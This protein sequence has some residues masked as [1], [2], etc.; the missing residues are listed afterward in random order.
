MVVWALLDQQVRIPR[1]HRGRRFPGRRI[2]QPGVTILRF[3]GDTLSYGEAN[4]QVNR[5]ANVLTAQGVRTGDVVGILME[6]KPEALLL[7]LGL[8]PNDLEG[9]V[10]AMEAKDPR[11]AVLI[12]PMLG[13]TLAPTMITASQKINV[14]P[15]RA[16]LQVD[17]RVP[18]GLGVAVELRHPS[19]HQESVYDLLEREVAF[20]P[21]THPPRY[22]AVRSEVDGFRVPPHEYRLD[23][24]HVTLG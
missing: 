2:Q 4:A 13:V 8:D 14:I 16:E 19:W 7:E 15:S 11:F 20:V 21:I 9:S 17:C 12:E 1:L 6:N 22:Y 3:E 24:T 23:L 10:R 5:Y 18:P